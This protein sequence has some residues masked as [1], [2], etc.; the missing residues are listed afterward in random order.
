MQKFWR[1]FH[2]KYLERRKLNFIRWFHSKFP[3]KYCW[4][5]CV[6]WSYSPYKF[7]PFRIDS[8]KGCQIESTTHSTNSCYCGGWNNGKC[9]DKLTQA[10]KD[11]IRKGIT[12]TP[13][14]DL[15]F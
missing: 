15:P 9:F 13:A 14:I 3:D 1:R 6:S 2:A 10:E 7:N 4:A 5:D 12:E 11:E 8:A